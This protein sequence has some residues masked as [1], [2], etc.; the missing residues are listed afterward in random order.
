MDT[1]YVQVYT[2]NGKGKTTAAFGLAMC[3]YNSAETPDYDQVP[4][5]LAID[6]IDDFRARFPNDERNAVL[7]EKRVEMRERI[8]QQRLRTA[9]F[10]ERRRRFE[11]AEIYYEVVV[12][13]FPETEAASEARGWLDGRCDAKAVQRK[14]RA[15]QSDGAG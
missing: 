14:V 9:H 8:A 1:G 5:Q 13:Q 3:Y 7:A 6:A 12:E 10:Y 11:A 2:G 15:P 4:S